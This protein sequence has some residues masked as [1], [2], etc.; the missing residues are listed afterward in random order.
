MTLP[1]PVGMNSGKA[2]GTGL[3]GLIKGDV[4]SKALREVVPKP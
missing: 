4:P 1:V 2:I 3:E